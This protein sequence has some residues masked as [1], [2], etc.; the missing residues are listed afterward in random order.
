MPRTSR[1][2]SET[3]IYHLLLR[4]INKQTIFEEDLDKKRFLQALKEYKAKSGYNLYAY[5]LMANH[6]HLLVKEGPEELGVAM[7]RIG[8]SYVYWYN[9]K[10]DRVGHLFQDRY[11]SEPVEDD[12]YFLAVLRYIHQNPV[13]AG[14]VPEVKAYPWSSYHEYVS[15][16][17]LVDTEFVLSLFGKNRKQAL[18]DFQRF[19]TEDETASCLDVEERRRISDTEAANIIKSV[20]NIPH[21]SD[22]QKLDRQSRSDYIKILRKKGLSTRQI[23][24][25]TG[26]CRNVIVKA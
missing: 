12:R 3:G 25:L 9:V 23:S 14:V 24:R 19:H 5:C 13:K 26:L 11:R 2:K 1:K 20:C 21:C 22:L 4:G 16:P 10:Y 8:A 6:V 17:D 18:S 7:R 15:K